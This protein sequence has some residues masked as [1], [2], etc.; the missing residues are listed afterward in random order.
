V[1][2]RKEGKKGGRE[3]GREKEKQKRGPSNRED[4]KMLRSPFPL[5]TFRFLIL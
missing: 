4:R 1:G 5:N 2:G 3:R